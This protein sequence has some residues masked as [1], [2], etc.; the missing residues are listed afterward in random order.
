MRFLHRWN[1]AIL[2]RGVLQIRSVNELAPAADHLPN[3][4]VF[5]DGPTETDHWA[6]A[7]NEHEGAVFGRWTGRH[8]EPLHE[9][10]EAWLRA[11]I[12]ILDNNIRDP[13]QQFE[14]RIESDPDC[15][16][17]LL[18]QAERLMEVNQKGAASELLRRATAANPG[19]VGAW[20]RLGQS[21]ISTDPGQA[22]WALLKAFRGIRLPESIPTIYTPTASL[23]SDLAKLFPARDDGWERELVHF[24]SESVSDA[25][26]YDELA[27]I[28]FAGVCLANIHLERNERETAHTVLVDLLERARAFQVRGPMQEAVLTHQEKK[29]NWK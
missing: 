28:E 1:G 21:L 18:Q 4:V 7:P 2:Y 12:Y 14:A 3:I 15:G 25:G 11:T 13:N 6:Y 27:M 22:R 17:L 9:N 24:L 20:N 8:F 10:F 19:L 23:I 29:T 5:A 26:N 16:Y